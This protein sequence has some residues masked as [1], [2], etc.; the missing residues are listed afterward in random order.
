MTPIIDSSGQISEERAE[1]GP[2][3]APTGGGGGGGGGGV[4]AGFGGNTFATHTGIGSWVKIDTTALWSANG[5]DVATGTHLLIDGQDATSVFGY[6]QPTPSSPIVCPLMVVGHHV[7]TLGVHTSEFD[8]IWRG[9]PWKARQGGAPGNDSYYQPWPVGDII[10]SP[11]NN[12]SDGTPWQTHY[13]MNNGFSQV[14][15]TGGATSQVFCVLPGD[16]PSHV[17]AG[18][19]ITDTRTEVTIGENFSNQMSGSGTIAGSPPNGIDM[20]GALTQTVRFWRLDFEVPGDWVAPV[21]VQNSDGTFALADQGG[22]NGTGRWPRVR[23][24]LTQKP[25]NDKL[26]VV[27]SLDY[28]IDTHVRNNLLDPANIG[29]AIDP[30]NLSNLNENYGPATITW[31]S[32]SSTGV[33]SFRLNILSLGV[34]LPVQRVDNITLA[35]DTRWPTI[36]EYLPH[37]YAT[38]NGAPYIQPPGAINPYTGKA[39]S[40]THPVAPYGPP[41]GTPG[42]G[43]CRFWRQ[44]SGIWTC[45][46]AGHQ[47]AWPGTPTIVDGDIV[48]D[49]VHGQHAGKIFGPNVKCN[50]A[51]LVSGPDGSSGTVLHA[52][53]APP[54]DV[55]V[56]NIVHGVGFHNVGGIV[57]IDGELMLYTA[58]T[59]ATST[60]HV[61]QRAINGT[62][63]ADHLAGAQIAGMENWPTANP[64][65]NAQVRVPVPL[66]VR[67]WPLMIGPTFAS[68][69]GDPASN[70]P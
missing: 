4:P 24:A 57:S 59:S 32:P 28:P 13:A 47:L 7:I 14:P 48:G 52:A 15:D 69:A 27:G 42:G 34:F 25:I 36:V 18:G 61:T 33:F 9:Y 16:Q 8:V 70:F 56:N 64:G 22:N 63:A 45:T 23:G 49:P 66:A 5:G 37:L 40:A 17:P 43:Y 60:L 30:N 29:R 58:W 38:T 65:A 26:A 21:K 2:P 31:A 35:F 44:I 46:S 55:V 62:S 67:H 12:F 6:P 10:P 53:T 11:A 39:W 68:V 41:P 20:F 3:A 54:F 19:G 51:N 50:G 1:N